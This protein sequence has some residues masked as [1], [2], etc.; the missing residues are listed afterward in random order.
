MYVCVCAITRINCILNSIQPMFFL[1]D[2][3]TYRT[4][5]YIFYMLFIM[6]IHTYVKC[7]RAANIK[8]IYANIACVSRRR[9]QRNNWSD[10]LFIFIELKIH[11]LLGADCELALIAHTRTMMRSKRVLAFIALY[12]KWILCTI[13]FNTPLCCASCVCL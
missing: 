9:R 6:L 10:L 13:S 8:F 5:I 12:S 1:N 2:V 4:A 3:T 11:E 7:T